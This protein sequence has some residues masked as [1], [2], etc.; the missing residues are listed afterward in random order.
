MLQEKFKVLLQEKFKVLLQEKFIG[1][2]TRKI[3]RFVASFEVE[4][5]S[6]LA[7]LT[8]KPILLYLYFYLYYIIYYYYYIILLYYV[9]YLPVSYFYL[10]GFWSV[11]GSTELLNTYRSNLD[12]DPQHCKKVKLNS[13]PYI[14]TLVNTN[15][16]KKNNSRK[17]V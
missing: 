14:K 11:F 8:W 12:P 15:M 17:I 10:Y 3:Q 2:V 16:K 13:F 4:A 5:R 7:N 9:I 1:F 6:E